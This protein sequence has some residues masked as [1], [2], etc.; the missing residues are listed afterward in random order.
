MD[1][2]GIYKKSLDNESLK[3]DKKIC[4]MSDNGPSRDD[5]RATRSEWKHIESYVLLG[6]NG[7]FIRTLLFLRLDGSLG[8]PTLRE[9]KQHL[10]WTFRLS[11]PMKKRL[12]PSSS[13]SSSLR[14]E[15]L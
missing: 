11:Y 3:M 6:Q 7:G 9:G 10:R 4:Y 12:T 14:E 13:D 2:F 1:I 8:S 15:E 5:Y